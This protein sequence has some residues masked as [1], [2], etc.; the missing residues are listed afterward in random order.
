MIM[1][2]VILKAIN[3]YITIKDNN[4]DNYDENNAQSKDKK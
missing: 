2:T 1:I 3:S 4:N